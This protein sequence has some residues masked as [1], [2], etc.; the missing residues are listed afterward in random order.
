MLAKGTAENLLI[1]P[2]EAV[3]LAEKNGTITELY[4]VNE[5]MEEYRATAKNQS[6]DPF[7]NQLQLAGVLFSAGRV[8]G[9]RE[10]RAKR[11][12]A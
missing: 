8:Q 4:L 11:K 2:Q 6:T 9:V 10:E 1:T 5:I 3:K 7:F 12:N